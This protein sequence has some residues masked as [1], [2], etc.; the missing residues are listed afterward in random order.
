M[1]D[2]EEA[3]RSELRDQ[4]EAAD[5]A[6]SLLEPVAR[7]IR[8]ARRRYTLAASAMTVI[9]GV[10]VAVTVSA[11]SVL[12]PAVPLAG[13][14]AGFGVPNGLLPIMHGVPQTGAGTPPTTHRGPFAGAE[15]GG[16]E[17][18]AVWPALAR[19]VALA[20]EPRVPV[21]AG[22]HW[23]DFGEIRF[24]APASWAVERGA[25]W[26]GCSPEVAPRSVLLSTSAVEFGPGCAES[27]TAQVAPGVVVGTG[28]YAAAEATSGA[29]P[30]ACLR[31]DGMR[32]C[33]LWPGQDRWLSVAVFPPGAAGPTLVQIGLVS[34]AATARAIFDSIRPAAR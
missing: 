10:G 18:G 17:H 6:V 14:Q 2:L 34:P 11:S 24:A 3:L 20:H 9:A 26:D 31:L 30:G 8:R 7:R 33:L 29:A 23:H 13:K 16:A 12:Q 22:W 5:R 1:N 4:A 25:L 19:S 28:R 15:H 21:P 32:A 27:P